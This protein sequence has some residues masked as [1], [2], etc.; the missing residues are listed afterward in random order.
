MGM[1]MGTVM[2]IAIHRGHFTSSNTI[3][4]KESALQIRSVR[5]AGR[6]DVEGDSQASGR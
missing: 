2:G 5:D 4:V 6:G 3:H 1:P